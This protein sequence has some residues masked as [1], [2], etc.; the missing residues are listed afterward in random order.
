[1]HSRLKSVM[2]EGGVVATKKKFI[3]NHKHNHFL[4]GDETC[5]CL[6]LRS[7]NPLLDGY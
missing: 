2:K 5:F 7:S 3:E 1:M 6:L 4:H